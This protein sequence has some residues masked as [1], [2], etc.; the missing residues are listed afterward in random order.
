MGKALPDATDYKEYMQS[1]GVTYE[2]FS[3]L[4]GPCDGDDHMELLTGELVTSIGKKYNKTGAQVAL[5]WQT[6]QGIPVIPKSAN[7]THIAQ[8][9]GTRWLVEGARAS[10]MHIDRVARSCKLFARSSSRLPASA[11]LA[12]RSLLVDALRRGHVGTHGSG[13]ASGCW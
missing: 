4:C 2:G 12:C 7:P 13:Q 5:K 6:Q 10:A 3:P 11:L 1:Q 9:L 8:N